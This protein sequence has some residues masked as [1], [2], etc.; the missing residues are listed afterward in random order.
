MP[1]TFFSVMN[2]QFNSKEFIPV[3]DSPSN[4]AVYDFFWNREVP[5]VN[6]VSFPIAVFLVFY[7]AWPVLIAVGRAGTDKEA[8]P[9]ELIRLRRR[10]LWVG[11]SAAWL[12]M[13]LWTISGIAIPLWENLHFGEIPGVGMKQYGNFLA[14]Q[15]ACGWISSTLTYFLL[16]FMFV[17]AF[18]PVLIKPD[19]QHSDEADHLM[20]LNT[21]CLVCFVMTFSAPFFAL[22]LLAFHGMKQEGAQKAW[23]I[24]LTLIG[25]VVSIVAFFI[26]QA[27]RTDIEAL[28]VAVDPSRDATS[29][30]TDT[31]DSVWTGTR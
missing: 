29:V 6:L 18:Y 1:S 22:F 20:R 30:S 23:M 4:T 16:T 8:A 11:D 25:F 13:G 2:I 14:S 26:M 27:I 3:P 10:A 12:G 21:R 9:G 17:R 7:V 24:I 15:I 31:V 28:A 5:V 19:Q